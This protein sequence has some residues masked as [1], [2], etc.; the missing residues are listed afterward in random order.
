MAGVITLLVLLV[1]GSAGAVLGAGKGRAGVGLALGLFLGVIGIIIIVLLPATEEQAALDKLRSGRKKCPFCA[2]LVRGEAVMCKHCSQPIGAAAPPQEEVEGPF[3]FQGVDYRR[4]AE[5]GT[6]FCWRCRTTGE[7]KDLLLGAGS[8]WMHRDCAPQ[9]D[10]A[11]T[12]KMTGYWALG[13]VLIGVVIV[14]FVA[15]VI[16]ST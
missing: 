4:S 5:E 16:R 10:V 14:A 11:P 7:K 3:H 6:A 8:T 9:S 1:C 15:A 2:E 12:D 13:A